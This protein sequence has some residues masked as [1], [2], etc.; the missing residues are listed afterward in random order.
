MMVV[1]FTVLLALFLA[2]ADQLQVRLLV[3]FPT[4]R[5]FVIGAAATIPP[6]PTN[7]ATPTPLLPTVTLRPG[8][9]PP[10]PTPTS[11]P[12]VSLPTPCITPPG[13]QTYIIKR[14]DT[15]SAIA[16]RS[17]KTVDDIL[18]G[19]CMDL[20]TVLIPGMTMLIPPDIST[21]LVGCGPLAGWVYV[22]VQRG[23]TLFSLAR[24]YGTTVDLIRFAN[25]MDN[26]Y[27]QAGRRI[28]LPYLAPTVTPTAANTPVPPPTDTPVPTAT[29][30]FTPEPT[31]TATSL[32]TLPPPPTLTPTLAPPDTATPTPT[33]T[34]TPEVTAT[35]TE[36]PTVTVTPSPI[37]TDTPSPTITMTLEPTVTPSSTPL[38]PTA[39]PTPTAAPGT[40]PTATGTP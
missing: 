31:A 4:V 38:P 37:V 6:S 34:A 27:L 5:P 39:T 23:D 11:I 29:S 21:F 14:G 24:R 3:P 15:L 33:D 25:C 2:Q 8:L 40:T 9:T 30:T 1:T 7:T 13:W 19:N 36:T 10:T 16:L 22:T 32:P 35:F 26:F 20:T 18:A 17:M 12:I 28:V